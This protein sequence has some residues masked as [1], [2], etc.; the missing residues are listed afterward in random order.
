MGS[1]FWRLLALK[2]THF[3][4]S[5]GLLGFFVPLS[6]FFCFVKVLEFVLFV[7]VPGTGSVIFCMWAFVWGVFLV[8]AGFGNW[9]EFYL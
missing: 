3:L 5:W 8:L 2:R 7:W 4:G 9:L 1:G 6:F